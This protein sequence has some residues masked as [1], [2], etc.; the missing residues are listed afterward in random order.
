MPGSGTHELDLARMRRERFAKLQGAMERDGIDAL[1]LLAS[2]SVLYATGAWMLAAD[3]GRATHQRVGALVVR[4]GAAPHLFTPYA[5]G[6]PAALPGD[7]VHP[8]L[9]PETDAGVD[10]SARIVA[11]LAAARARRI[12][13]DVFTVPMW[14]RLPNLLAPAELPSA[15]PL[16]TACRLH[17]TPDELECRRRSWWMN[18]AA[19]QAAEQALRPGVRMTD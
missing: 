14:L 7:H 9:W 12:P 18:E 17:K 13:L 6:A 5:E 10:E 3:N 4:G 15:P 8:P 19:S 16:L 1:L 2:G 11:E